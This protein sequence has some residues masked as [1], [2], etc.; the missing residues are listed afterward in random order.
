MPCLDKVCAVCPSPI[1]ILIIASF[2]FERIS[3]YITLTVFIL[4]V[5][6]NLWFYKNY[7]CITS[8][9]QKIKTLVRGINLWYNFFK[10]I[11]SLSWI[12]IKNIILA[13]LQKSFVLPDLYSLLFKMIRK[14][15]KKQRKFNCRA[16]MPSPWGEGAEERGGWGVMFCAPAL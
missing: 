1:H 15:I 8:F 4:K 16:G 2:L 13:M 14:N 6:L 5:K 11:R 3:S 7:H 10:K 9:F 12:W